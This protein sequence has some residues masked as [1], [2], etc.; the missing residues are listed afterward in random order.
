QHGGNYTEFSQFKKRPSQKLID[1]LR[2]T[3]V[4]PNG[5]GRH[6]S[7]D[8][9]K[10]SVDNDNKSLVGQQVEVEPKIA[11]IS[12]ETT[13]VSSLSGN[14]P[15]S[16]PRNFAHKTNVSTPPRLHLPLSLPSNRLKL[17]TR[18]TLSDVYEDTIGSQE[19][20]LERAKQE[21]VIQ[22]RVADLRKQGLWSQRRLP[23]VQE[24]PRNKTH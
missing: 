6:R 14:R 3:P 15:I 13:P 21:A 1:H 23:K 9:R 2:Q 17:P 19:E 20:I 22:R 7:T 18:N 4:F 10:S 11:Q 5:D 12:I 24:P 16:S 8:S